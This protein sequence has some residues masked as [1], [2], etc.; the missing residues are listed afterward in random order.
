M[1]VRQVFY[2][3]VSRGLIEKTEREYRSTV[4]RFLTNMGLAHELP[5]AWI[6]DNSRSTPGHE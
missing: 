6:A 5:F 3:M 4:V 2:Q 1:T